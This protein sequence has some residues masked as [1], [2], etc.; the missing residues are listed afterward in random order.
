MG[1]SIVADATSNLFPSLLKK[2]NSHIIVMNMVLT[3]GNESYNCY[4]D[5]I[6]I[7]DFSKYYYSRIEE[8]VKVS[9]ALV[10]PSQYEETFNI[11][12]EKGNRIICFTMAKGIS[13]TYNSAV[14]AMNTINEKYGKKV[15]H[16]IDSLTAGFGE[17]LQALHAE[18]LVNQG[19]DYQD[20]IIKC[21]EYRYR[22][23]SE[24]TVDD[25]KYLLKTGR[26]SA[27]LARF[28][29]LTKIKLMLK[30]SEESK[31]V[32]F[33]PAL[34][35]KNAIKRLAENAAKQFD[36]HHKQ[37]LYITH[38]NIVEDANRIKEIL[39]NRGFKDEEI[40]IYD[41]DLISGAHIGPRAIALFY[42]AVS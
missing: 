9:T 25:I 11:E 12:A 42:V 21:E 27:A 16:V 13:G 36:H 19:L 35:R 6:N 17:G 7:E 1:I 10:N 14:T 38:C 32:M 29:K 39:L 40:E 28:L 24:F 4:H 3:L 15:V 20:I 18:E 2:K 8:G 37:I 23:R 33:A 22:V 30:N 26:A 31:I 34:G 5:D 41:Y